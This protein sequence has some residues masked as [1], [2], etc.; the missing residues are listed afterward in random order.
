[1]RIICH[2]PTSHARPRPPG[3]GAQ[4]EEP[5]QMPAGFSPGALCPP[6][7]AQHLLGEGNSLVREAGRQRLAAKFTFLGVN[8][9]SEQLHAG[10][11]KTLLGD[12]AER[13]L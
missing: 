12:L 9:L 4:A 13:V 10:R 2:R 1:M 11:V 5:C 3:V 7:A 6:P 8:A